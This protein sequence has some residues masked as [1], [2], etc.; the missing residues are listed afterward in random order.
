MK[1][2]YQLLIE[3]L[4]A[5]IRKY[6]K[7]QLIRGAIY[8]FG[9]CLAFYLAVTLLESV[10]RFNTG[11]RTVLFYSLLGGN[12]FI[13]VRFVVMPLT[14]L[15]RI[16]PVI[17]HEEAARIIGSHFSEVKDKLL[18]TLQLREQFGHTTEGQ[19]SDLVM[20]GINQKIDELKP[21]PFVTAVNLGENRKYL[22]YALVPLVLLGVVFFSSPSLIKD[23]TQRLIN[24]NTYFEKPA[25][26][27]FEVTN[28][29]L[30]AMQQSDFVLDVKVSGEEIPAAASIEIDGNLFKLEKENATTWHYTFRNVQKKVSFRLTADGFY[31]RSYLLEAL[32][33]PL[34]MNFEISLD[35]PAYLHKQAETVRN[36]G[37]LIIPAGTRASWKFN[38]RNTESLLLAFADTGITAGKKGNEEFAYAR[39]FFKSN[40]YTISTANQYLRSG[41]SL[42]FSVSV[43]PDLYPTISVEQQKDSNSTKRLFFKGLIKDDYGFSKLAFHYRYLKTSDS[44]A[45]GQKGKEFTDNLPVGRDQT[46]S[47]FYHYW[48]AGTL[49]IAAGDEVEYYFEVT[50]ND[51]ISGPKSTR[52]QTQVFKAPTLQE[53]EETTAKTSESIK[54]DLRES[55]EQARQLQK[56]SSE[57]NKKLLEKKEA[58]WEDKK[59]AQELMKKQEELAKKVEDIKKQNEQ[60][61]NLESEYKKPDS[62]LLEK[63]KQLQDLMEKIMSPELRKLLEDMQK[64]LDQADKQKL[65]EQMDNMKLD[66]KDLQKEL[67]RA[68][69]LFKQLEFQQ[70]LQDNIDKLDQLAEKQEDLSKQAEDKNSDAKDLKEKQEQLS[71][72][73]EDF[74]KDMEDMEKKN[75]ALEEPNKL[76]NTD[77]EQK[78]IKQDQKNSEEQLGN[79]QKSKAGKSQK[80]ASQK[81][82]QLAEKMGQMKENMEAEQAEEDMAALRALL[83]NLLRLSFDQEKLMQDLKTMDVNNPQYLK[84]MQEQRKL[85]DNAK[86]IEDSLTA[87]S[88]RVVQIQ[89]DVSKEINAINQNMDASMEH[90]E[91]RFIPQ[92]RSRQQ[93]VMTAVNNLALMLSEALN[94]MQKEAANQQKSGGK[95]SSSCKK[96][97]SGSPKSIGD[98]K[99][100]QEAL[101]KNMQKLKEQMK[102]QGGNKPM[103]GKTG[104]QGQGGMSEQLA[105][106]AAEQ[107]YI[108]N[109]LSKLNMQEN[110]D[111]KKSLGNLEEIAKKMEESENDIVNKMISD[112]TLQRQQEILTRLLESERAEREREQ[113]EQRKSTEA[114]NNFNRNPD[115]FEEYKRLKQKETELLR[116]VPPT[117]NSYYRKKVN[118]Y[119]QSIEK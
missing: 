7:N 18:N 16:G 77:S 72:E 37:D 94:Q 119:F 76:E 9:L 24:H 48:D 59:K 32:P 56:E 74:Q 25:P 53:V 61:N 85:K 68:L 86:M 90:L 73:F 6:Y 29:S 103:P 31:S 100:M 66:N 113:D 104:K 106:M 15:Y 114:K 27:A 21:V 118:D 75:A 79:N 45:A 105:K 88:K 69:E 3:K 40:T 63:Q 54:Q 92:A 35:Y 62:E 46:S 52:S 116:T 112:Q 28:K 33:N 13:L 98:L 17:S 57:L 49:N 78:D 117:L 10:G 20:A 30:L 36:T 102:Q 107:E 71:K 5:F 84:A 64:M 87:L 89:K 81:M 14:K 83:E 34:L 110:K 43:I 109:E 38:T 39:R 23:S 47:Q 115:A 4:D 99:K 41:D 51:G 11:L 82:K 65:Q 91:A 19:H 108:R 67:D 26:F 1:D 55:I 50:D 80:G 93:Y 95:P 12:L 42:H 2:N 60:K 58:G 96:P 8:S 97:G 44:A 111:G 101:N 70:K 22:R